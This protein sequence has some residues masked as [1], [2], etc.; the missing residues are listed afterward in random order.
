MRGG[1][2]LEIRYFYLLFTEV[3]N[4]YFVCLHLVMY[5]RIIKSF[6]RKFQIL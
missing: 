1:G 2:V 6:T 5:L 3:N 4:Q